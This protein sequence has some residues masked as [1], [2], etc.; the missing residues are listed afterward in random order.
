MAPRSARFQSGAAA[1]VVL[2]LCGV[3]QNWQDV[4]PATSVP[5]TVTLP[6]L[7]PTKSCLLPE[8]AASA[9]DA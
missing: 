8:I 7:P 1:F 5:Y 4:V 3:W 9:D 6:A 2:A